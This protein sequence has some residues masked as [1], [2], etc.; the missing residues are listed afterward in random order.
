[1]NKITGVLFVAVLAITSHM[2]V[3]RELSPNEKIVIEDVAK[4]QLKDP[5]SAKF[6]W[7]DYKGG[8]TYCAYVN[9]KNAYGGFAGKALLIASVKKDSAGKIVSAE[10]II[11]SDD[12]RKLMGS[13]CTDA[14]YQP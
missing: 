3:A 6:F 11:H 5:D 12:M 1:M 4:Q 7:Q 10:G 14:G 8:E 13:V 2:A 9:A